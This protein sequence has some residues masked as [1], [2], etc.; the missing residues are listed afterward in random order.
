MLTL[1]PPVHQGKCAEGQV[2]AVTSSPWFPGALLHFLT[3][4]LSGDRNIGT[5]LAM[6]L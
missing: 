5:T 4:H 1:V 6:T 2:E 3:I